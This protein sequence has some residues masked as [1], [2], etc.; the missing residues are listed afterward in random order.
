MIAETTGILNFD[1]YSETND[2]TRHTAHQGLPQ[3][4]YVSALAIIVA[5]STKRRG[6]DVALDSH[7]MGVN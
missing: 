3:A 4:S 5:V 1:Q 2:L 7:F 6:F